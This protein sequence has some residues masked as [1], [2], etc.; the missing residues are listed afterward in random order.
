MSF[1]QV[2]FWLE[3][4]EKKL[5]LLGVPP[6]H[7]KLSPNQ[8]W[9]AHTFVSNT[10]WRQPA[11]LLLAT[12][13]ESFSWFSSW[14]KFKLLRFCSVALKVLK[15]W[16]F[17]FFFLVVEVNM[18]IISIIGLSGSSL[19]TMWPLGLPRFREQHSLLTSSHWYPS[20]EPHT[21][22]PDT[23]LH[24]VLREQG[25]RVFYK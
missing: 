7:C 25:L 17:F 9:Y 21:H 6:L 4:G 16:G 20:S 19:S 22:H 10:T 5:W 2:F 12:L 8:V 18:V 14:E 11:S 23:N 1:L 3:I 13:W 15:M 24:S